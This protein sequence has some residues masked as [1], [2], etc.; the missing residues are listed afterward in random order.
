MVI[1]HNVKNY[2]FVLWSNLLQ[3][4]LKN[5]AKQNKNKTISNHLKSVAFLEKESCALFTPKG[6]HQKTEQLHVH[7]KTKN[8]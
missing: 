5:K 1:Y 7:Y 8:I 6:D 2:N 4:K 3:F